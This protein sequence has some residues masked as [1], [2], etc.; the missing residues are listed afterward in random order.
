MAN[1]IPQPARLNVYDRSDMKCEWC[2]TT[3]LNNYCHPVGSGLHH[4]V[5]RVTRIHTEE[6][7]ILLCCWD[8]Y[9]A[10][11]TDFGVFLR[12]RLQEYYFKQGYSEEEVRILMGNKL[13]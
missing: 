1:N 3:N 10:E 13:Y 12:K 8:H 4:I 5:P 9:R 11:Y 2:G 6:N 7:L